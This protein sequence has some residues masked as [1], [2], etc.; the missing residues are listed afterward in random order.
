MQYNLT[1]VLT[2]K[3]KT[4]SKTFPLEADTRCDIW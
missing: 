1:D 3:T 4:I 2:G